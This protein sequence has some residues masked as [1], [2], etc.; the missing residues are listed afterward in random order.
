V[1]SLGAHEVVGYTRDDFTRTGRPADVVF[2]LV[3][4]RSLRDLRRAL[5]PT[6]TLVLSG[7]GTSTGGSLV[8]PLGLV[9]RGRMMSSFVR[10][11]IALLTVATSR[12]NLVTLREFAE[13]GTLSPVIDR[14]FALAPS[15]TRSATWKP[16]TP[17][18]R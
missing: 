7:G 14:T 8:G 2:D 6:G 15:P 4:N 3:A 10:Q 18:R 11:R 9:I 13:A 12:A 1:R 17:V 5:T 16:N